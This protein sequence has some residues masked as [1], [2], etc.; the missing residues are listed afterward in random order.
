[1][2]RP[3]ILVVDD[4][5]GMLR[6]IERVLA[7]SCDVHTARRPPR[8]SRPPPPSGSELALPRHPHARDGRLRADE[9]AARAGADLDVILMTGST[10]ERDARLVRAIREK[11]FFFLTKPFDRE[12]L[13][14]LVER[15][16][17]LRRLDHDNRE[18]LKRLEREL[19]AARVFQQ[20]LLPPPAAARGGL[21]VAYEYC[22]PASSCA[23]TSATTGSPTAIAAR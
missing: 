20:S 18:H 2:T 4:E 6:A 17:D 14:T 1:M 13:I 7:S 16:L 11:A 5:P 9:P 21:D 22:S 10:D 19:A 3:R 12:V 23:A 8:R 15:C